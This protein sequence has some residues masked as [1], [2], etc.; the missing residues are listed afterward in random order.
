MPLVSL[1]VV[2][3]ALLGWSG[4]EIQPSRGDRAAASYRSV[5]AL[6]RPTERTAETLKRYNLER[7]YR[8]D[9]NTALLHIEKYA[10]QRLEPELVY[11]LAELSW[12]EG[13][14]LDRKRKPQALDRYLDTAAYA[15]DFL[16]DPDP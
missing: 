2:A 14:R 4:I 7:E 11:A 10:Q 12:I 8:R 5:A 6:D 1:L 9:V 3:T 16:F 15:F 13:K